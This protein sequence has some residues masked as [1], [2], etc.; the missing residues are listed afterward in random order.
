MRSAV[1]SNRFLCTSY[2]ACLTGSGAERRLACGWLEGRVFYMKTVTKACFS[3]A[4]IL[5]ACGSDPDPNAGVGT[6]GAG[7]HVS[8]PMV[9]P[10]TTPMV[11]TPTTTPPPTVTAGANG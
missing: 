1:R 6:S 3:A 5:T 7:P 2:T 8:A 11:Q 4:L 10:G 9:L